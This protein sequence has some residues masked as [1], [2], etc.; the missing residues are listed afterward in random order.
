MSLK[1]YV[2]TNIIMDYLLARTDSQFITDA[3]K[4]KF[5]IVVSELVISELRFQ[6]VHTQAHT[7]FAWL[8]TCKKITIVQ[9][10][11]KEI[12]LGKTFLSLT[13]HNDALHA[14][15]AITHKVDF[16]LTRNMKDFEK[17]PLKSTHPSQI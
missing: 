17:L 2:D 5:H 1:V 7:L 16:L 11:E 12:E 15:C 14:A 6:N 8:D 3:L 10:S 4:C 9:I 13:H